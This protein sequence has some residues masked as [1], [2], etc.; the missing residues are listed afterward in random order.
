MQTQ[1][2]SAEIT[3]DLGTDHLPNVY[4]TATLIRA[5][6]QPE[7]PLMSAHGMK[8][9]KVDDPK[10]RIPI[11]IAAV[12]KSRSKTKQRVDV[13]TSPNTELTIAVVDEGILQLKN[14]ETPKINEYFYQ[15]RALGVRSFDLYPLLLPEIQL[16]GKSST[17][18]DGSMGKRVNPLAN[19]RAELVAKWSGQIKS[20]ASGKASFEFD[21]PEF[22]GS[23][24]I[25][26]VAYDDEKFG[27]EEQK[28][29]VSDPVSISVGMPLFL[30]P[31]DKVKVPVTFFN[32]TESPQ[33]VKLSTQ[34][35]GQI[36]V[37]N[38]AE[39]SI[40]I[41]PGKE[42]HLDLEVAGKD[43][44]GLGKLKVLA[45]S[46]KET[47]SKTTEISGASCRFI[48]KIWN[49]GHFSKKYRFGFCCT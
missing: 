40:T 13:R 33:V 39:N 36:S 4:I 15:K 35:E 18:G 11:V 47:F 5:M 34:T 14:T 32:T 41:E 21:I 12:E 19:G 28:M 25:M 2:K 31:T 24:R 7:L 49:F 26:V 45:K 3:I 23:L 9:I 8:T 10:R 38:F 37:G 48:A 30:S 46:D 44:I 6:N 29:T 16:N 17:G 42:K 27:S 43:K 22:L 1:N 20:D